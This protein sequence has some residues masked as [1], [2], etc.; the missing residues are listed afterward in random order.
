MAI[1]F[2]LVSATV[3][4]LFVVPGLYLQ[5]TPDVINNTVNVSGGGTGALKEG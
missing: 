3:I 1:V 5:L 2:G 4:A